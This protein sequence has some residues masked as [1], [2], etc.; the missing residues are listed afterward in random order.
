M[1]TIEFYNIAHGTM[2]MQLFHAKSEI[3]TNGQIVK[4][5]VDVVHPYN[6]HPL[7]TYDESFFIP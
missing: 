7:S 6:V 4:R 1:A 2:H 5:Y 3:N